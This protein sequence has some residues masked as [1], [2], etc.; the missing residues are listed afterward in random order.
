MELLAHLMSTDPATP[1]LTVYDESTG[2]RL[3]FSAQTLD[4][5]TAKVGNMLLDELDLDGDST[6]LLAMPV[7][8]QAAV[9]ALGALAADVETHFGDRVT[10]AEE[11]THVDVV[12]TSLTRAGEF[13]DLNGADVVLVTDDPF[14]R[15]VTETGGDLPAGAI[16]FGPTVRFYGD[17][18][19]HPTRALTEIVTTELGPERILATGWDDRDSFVRQVLEP[20]AAGGSSVIVAGLVEAERLEQIATAEKTT[21]RL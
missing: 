9:I 5:W 21:L 19:L 15:G 13:T 17:Q 16:D 20:L 6:I 18:F 4:N 2:A 3:D 14:G 8:W 10:D 11:A 1:R 7:G 12:F